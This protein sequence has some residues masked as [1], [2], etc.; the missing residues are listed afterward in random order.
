MS[1]ALDSNGVKYTTDPTVRRIRGYYW[2][3]YDYET[4]E[5]SGSKTFYDVPVISEIFNGLWVGG[6]DD[7][8]VLPTS[9]TDVISLHDH[10]AYTI[11]HD[12]RS[13][14]YMKMVDSPDQELHFLKGLSRWILSRYYSGGTVL[15]HCHMGLN[16]SNVAV[17]AAL[18]VSGYRA[19]DAI[20]LLREKR[21]PASLCNTHFERYLRQEFR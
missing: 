6:I 18:M 13:H 8:L 20:N 16:R 17:A 15:V 4:R 7:G 5:H 14:L 12:L 21:S 2:E 3:G 19:E 11:N 10:S 9:I 1:Y